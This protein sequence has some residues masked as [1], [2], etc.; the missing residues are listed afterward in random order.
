MVKNGE[1]V[2]G[3]RYACVV[4]E[5]LSSCRTNCWFG[6]SGV[7][8]EERR[9]GGKAIRLVMAYASHP[10]N[11]RQ[12]RRSCRRLSLSVGELQGRELQGQQLSLRRPL[13]PFHCGDF[14]GGSALFDA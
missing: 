8:S 3:D 6:G 9:F 4:V 11:W 14:D 10:R 7:A 2:V 1:K 12:Y 5:N 13:P